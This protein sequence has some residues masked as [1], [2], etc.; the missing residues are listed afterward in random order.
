HRT[1]ISSRRQCP[2]SGQVGSSRRLIRET[3]RDADT[4][5]TTTLTGTATSSSQSTDG[6]PTPPKPRTTTHTPPPVRRPQHDQPANDNSPPEQLLQ[7]ALESEDRT[8]RYPVHPRTPP[9]GVIY[10]RFHTE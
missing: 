4:A 1:R 8:T 9:Y 5:T 2:C 10:V 7:P 6:A 3:R